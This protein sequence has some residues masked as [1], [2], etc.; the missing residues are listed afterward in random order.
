MADGFEN[1]HVCS[2]ED[3]VTSLGEI[4][5]FLLG[6]VVLVS[7]VTETVDEGGTGAYMMG[8]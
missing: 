5:A 6:H 1:Q 2:P 8:G 7:R 4:N 3:M